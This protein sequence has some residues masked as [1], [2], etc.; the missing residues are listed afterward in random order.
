MNWVFHFQSKFLGGCHVPGLFLEKYQCLVWPIICYIVWV[1]G[2][3]KVVK[4]WNFKICIKFW[5]NLWQ[6]PSL[7]IISNL[8]WW[9][10]IWVAKGWKVVGLWGHIVGTHTPLPVTGSPRRTLHDLWELFCP[11]MYPAQW[12][13]LV[14]GRGL[15]GPHCPV[16]ILQPALGEGLLPL[17]I[18]SYACSLP[19]LI[20]FSLLRL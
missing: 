12:E 20:I 4:R 8:T 9:E 5:E 7:P 1:K 14:C 3:G 18:E 16:S 17:Y 6:P 10:I 2:E 13:R 11:M 19:Q 15:K